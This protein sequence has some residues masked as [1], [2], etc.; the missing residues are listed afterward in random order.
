M[1][2]LAIGLDLVESCT[3]FSSAPAGSATNAAAAAITRVR[4]IPSLGVQR[5][6]LH[7]IVVVA[8]RVEDERSSS[9]A[10]TINAF[11]PFFAVKSKVYG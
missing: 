10:L 1:T 9:M 2:G 6:I 8:G 7:H 3:G 11:L 4:I 5:D